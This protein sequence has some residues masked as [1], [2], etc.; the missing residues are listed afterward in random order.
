MKNLYRKILSLGVHRS[1]PSASTSPV[2]LGKDAKIMM[3]STLWGVRSGTITARATDHEVGDTEDSI[4]GAP[5]GTAGLNAASGTTP[6]GGLGGLLQVAQQQVAAQGTVTAFESHQPG[7]QVCDI[8]ITAY[9]PFSQTPHAS[10]MN[11]LQGQYIGNVM[12]F[13][14]GKPSLNPTFPQ[15]SAWNFPYILVTEVIGMRLDINQPIEISFTGKSTGV[16]SAP[17]A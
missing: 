3:N 15:A 2:S 7:R 11:I 4:F 8:N 5:V 9:L 1:W 12:I 17:S 16:F 10:A 13:P 6:G 14:K